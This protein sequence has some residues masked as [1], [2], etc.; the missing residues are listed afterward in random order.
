[1]SSA[2]RPLFKKET[3]SYV[4]SMHYGMDITAKLT[5]KTPEEKERDRLNMTD[6]KPVTEK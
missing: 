3:F 1:M 6:N 5:G 4:L 2:A